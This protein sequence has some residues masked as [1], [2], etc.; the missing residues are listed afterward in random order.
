MALN[1]WQDGTEGGTPLSAERLNERDAAIESAASTATWGSVANKPS[2]FAPKIGT[3][4][5]DAAAGNHT[6]TAADVGAA[7]AS[8]THTV[9]QVSG[10][11]A[12]LDG[13]ASTSV[14]ADLETRLAALE[15]AAG[16]A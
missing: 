15:A 5:T 7:P 10:L 2:T 8:H 16:G 13:K 3:G 9:A 6:H 14:T 12:A 1:D 4:A 11:Q